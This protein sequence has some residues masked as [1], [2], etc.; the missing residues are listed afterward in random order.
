MRNFATTTRNSLRN[1]CVGILD[2]VTFRGTSN[3]INPDNHDPATYRDLLLWHLH[4][5]RIMEEGQHKFF[6]TA[7]RQ[8]QLGNEESLSQHQT[9]KTQFEG[10]VAS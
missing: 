8:E 3:I 6:L 7:H 9:D 1:E 10:Q 2:L 4:E 5:S